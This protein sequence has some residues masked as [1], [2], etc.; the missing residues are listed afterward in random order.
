ML[1]KIC[2]TWND[3]SHLVVS[4]KCWARISIVWK[5]HAIATLPPSSLLVL[6]Y[7]YTVAIAENA[8]WATPESPPCASKSNGVSCDQCTVPWIGA[9]FS[10]TWRSSGHVSATLGK[11]Q[12][13]QR[14][15]QRSQPNV[16]A[17]ENTRPERNVKST[18]KVDKQK[19][20]KKGK[21]NSATENTVRCKA[22]AH[23]TT[24]AR[25]YSNVQGITI[26]ATVFIQVQ[27]Y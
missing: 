24:S 17:P 6:R 15:Y 2:R 25:V 1:L 21:G 10:P 14:S 5:I 8:I 13:N 9:N 16:L 12:R 26:L 4:K 11:Q 20:T 7:L 18:W 27:Q 22:K 3:G 19:R 23:S